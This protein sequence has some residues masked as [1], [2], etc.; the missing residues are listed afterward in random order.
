[1]S[2]RIKKK[3]SSQSERITER[4]RDMSN[5]LKKENLRSQRERERERFRLNSSDE[6]IDAFLSFLLLHICS[7]AL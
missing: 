2:K 1:M 5:G 7:F 6:I 3:I 4:K